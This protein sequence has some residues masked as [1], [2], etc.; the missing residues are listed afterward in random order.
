[1]LLYYWDLPP[2]ETYE[3][4]HLGDFPFSF[5]GRDPPSHFSD[6]GES[7]SWPCLLHSSIILLPWFRVVKYGWKK[8]N[9]RKCT[10]LL[11]FFLTEVYLTYGIIL[12]SSVQCNDS[13]F[14]LVYFKSSS[15]F[16]LPVIPSFSDTKDNLLYVFCWRYSVIIRGVMRWNILFHLNW[17]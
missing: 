9:T 1:M 11:V 4:R 6:Q 2:K 14:V 17:S 3:K 10:S 12:V 5:F 7:F 16:N 15:L 13:I 8:K